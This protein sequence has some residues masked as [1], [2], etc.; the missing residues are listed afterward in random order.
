VYLVAHAQK[1]IGSMSCYNCAALEYEIPSLIF[2]PPHHPRDADTRRLVNEYTFDIFAMMK[3]TATVLYWDD[4]PVD[5]GQAVAQ[6]TSPPKMKYKLHIQYVNGE[7][8]L[9]N[10]VASVKDIGNIHIWADGCPPGTPPVVAGAMVH[11]MPPMHRA[12]SQNTTFHASWD[13]DVCFYMHHDGRAKPGVAKK[14]LE[15]TEAAFRSGEKWGIIYSHYDV[16]CAFNMKAVREVGFW[17]DAFYHYV[18]DNDYYRRLRLAGYKEL[19]FGEEGV[20]HIGSATVGTDPL[21]KYRVDFMHDSDR[22]YYIK[23]WGGKH[24]DLFHRWSRDA[25][26]T[27]Q[28]QERF[29]I[30]FQDFVEKPVR[31]APGVAPPRFIPV[32]GDPKVA[33]SDGRQ[34]PARLRGKTTVYGGRR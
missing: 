26:P 19:E 24:A 32:I 22:A 30:P 28:G 34:W 5:V 13:D 18:I 10:A 12:T 6:W 16:L 29:L 27:G 4:L 9:R 7:E 15:F 20:E 23:K 14:F 11:S 31:R 25:N 8:L 3:K 1:F 2:A 17:D 21:F 33:G